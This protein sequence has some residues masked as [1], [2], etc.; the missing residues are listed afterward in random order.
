MKKSTDKD[1]KKKQRKTPFQSVQSNIKIAE[2][3]RGVVITKD[4]R[5][6]K[7]MEISPIPF[8]LYTTNEQYN[9]AERFENVILQCPS[10]V[11]FTAITLP[12]DLSA[13]KNYLEEKIAQEKTVC[14][15]RMAQEYNGVIVN[16]E[17]TS[18]QRRFF[19]SFEY[20]RDITTR[21]IPTI[22]VICDNLN[23]KA[24]QI[25]RALNDCGNTVIHFGK[26]SLL[27]DQ[28]EKSENEAVEEILYQ[29]LNRNATQ[30]YRERK[31]EVIQR[32][33]DY[34]EE[35]KIKDKQIYI[36]PSEY[37]S[38]F[39]IGFRSSNYVIVNNDT[40]YTFAYFPSNGYTTYVE[41]GWLTPFINAVSGVD[42]NI[43]I[44]RDESDLRKQRIMNS[45]KFTKG[46]LYNSK[47]DTLGSENAEDSLFSG[48]YLNEGLRNGKRFYYATVM[49]TIV[50]TSAE[51]CE[52][53]YDLLQRMCKLPRLK[54][55]RYKYMEELAYFS[56]LPFGKMDPLLFKYGKRNMLDSGVSSLYPFTTPEFMDPEGVL[57]GID[58]MT[59][60]P[61]M[62]N[63]WNNRMFVNMNIGIFGTAGGG[64][65]V[66]I[67]T[68]ATRLR[69]LQVPIIIFACEKQREY[70]RVTEAVGGQFISLATG[71]KDCINIMEI[72]PRD[73]TVDDDAFSDVSSRSYLEA[74]ISSL[75]KWIE[76]KTGN[77]TP[78]DESILNK[79]IHETYAQEPFN[80]TSDNESLFDPF[81][82]EHKR[83]KKMPTLGDLYNNLRKNLRTGYIADVLSYFVEGSGR[84]FNGQTNVEL[85]N[86]FIVFGLEGMSDAD[87]PIGMYLAMDFVW[88]KIKEDSKARKC[89]FF[90]EFWKVCKSKQ[91]M[92]LATEMIRLVR[93]Y[94][95]SMVVAT[96][97]LDDL[98]K[99]DNGTTGQTILE[100]TA[101]KFLLKT[102][103][104]KAP[105]IGKLLNLNQQ[106]I[107]RL[108][109]QKPGQCL[110]SA[111][112][113]YVHLT[114]INGII[115]RYLFYTDKKTKDEW[116]ENKDKIEK[117]LFSAD[118]EYNDK[119]KYQ[120]IVDSIY[121][122]SELRT[123]TN[124]SVTTANER[125]AALLTG[126]K[127][128]EDDTVKNANNSD[129]FDLDMD[130]LESMLD[131]PEK[132][133]TSQDV[134]DNI[135][136]SN[137]FKLDDKFLNSLL[138][139]DKAN[140]TGNMSER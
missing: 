6:I 85:N 134:A 36:A 136:S 101:T 81:D 105:Y 119:K 58:E 74:K 131:I 29:I 82:I 99:F 90:D 96:Q 70:L 129:S 10:N 140:D 30:S 73:E 133:E 50:G 124:N 39:S 93:A 56:A 57:F 123:N 103:Q 110:F 49:F 32:Y 125:L 61:V 75:I 72:I 112:N 37:L 7:I 41:P 138:S 3:Y 33:K 68:L 100:N 23:E 67:L 35:H 55:S 71:S 127:I 9:I 2:I 130:L 1:Q 97:S 115:E 27:N 18:L 42:I 16:H 40:Y 88:S 139:E 45:I 63:V 79:V 51:D 109:S 120:Q 111:N 106:Q 89:V 62:A 132:G 25:E 22:N 5:Y 64:K 80:I 78:A 121:R 15:K 21:E 38:P 11:Q 31:N 12:A 8:T 60:S 28:A 98:M 53:K 43:Y 92:D 14:V 113:T 95:C 83:F 114:I 17:R 54:L 4:N 66:A 34:I 13:Q 48:R 77:L 122:D 47:D 59:N 137:D 44:E 102:A 107:K 116:V 76:L 135:D 24:V 87:F 94:S 86:K 26:Q 126:R 69:M 65:T 117:L 118:E 46:D 19:I 108:Y 91:S 104:D 52:Q 20:V 128:A 84:S